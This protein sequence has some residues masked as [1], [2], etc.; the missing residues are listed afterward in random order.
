ME[1][2]ADINTIRRHEAEQEKSMTSVERCIKT[3]MISRG[4]N[5]SYEQLKAYQKR[6]VDEDVDMML[7]DISGNYDEDDE[8]VEFM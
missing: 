7:K 6:R 3:V 1:I 2:G 4:F 8:L 5:C